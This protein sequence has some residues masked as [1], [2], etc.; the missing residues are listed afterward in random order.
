MYINVTFMYVELINLQILVR[1]HLMYSTPR[2][3]LLN[4]CYEVEH[5]KIKD[6]LSFLES[7]VWFENFR[8]HIQR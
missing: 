5:F 1:M 7:T 2:K 4:I 8:L 3:L 6:N